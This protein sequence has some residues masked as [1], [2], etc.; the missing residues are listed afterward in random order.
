MDFFDKYKN[1]YKSFIK[2]NII[3][4]RKKDLKN[5][6]IP[7]IYIYQSTISKKGVHFIT[8]HIFVI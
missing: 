6:K 8:I 7:K 5:I 4:I 2:D 1:Q 3:K